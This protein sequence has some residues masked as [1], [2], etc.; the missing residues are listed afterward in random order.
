MQ[1]A[2]ALRAAKPR[3]TNVDRPKKT[4]TH[5]GIRIEMAMR[6]AHFSLQY[7]DGK[8]GARRGR[9]E[10]GVH[11]IGDAVLPCRVLPSSVSL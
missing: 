1:G 11:D 6:V 5:E 2:A 7:R 8:E 9:G 10:G 4:T 3:V